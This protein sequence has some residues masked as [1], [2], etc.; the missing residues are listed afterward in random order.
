MKIVHVFI[1]YSIKYAGGTSD[2][3]YKI[4]K[5]QVDSGKNVE[6]WTGNYNL[7]DEL[8]DLSPFK[9]KIFKSFFDKQGLSIMPSLFFYAIFNLKKDDIIHFHVIRT[10]QNLILYIVARLKGINY[11]IDAHGAVP[12]HKKKKIL[13]NIYD[14][15]IGNNFIKNANSI[16]AES[17]IGAEEYNASY[18]FLDYKNIDILSPPFDVSDYKDIQKKYDFD[19]R[20]KNQ[21]SR[22][23]FVI[24]FLG[25]IH[26]IKGVDILIKFFNEILVSNSNFRLCIVGSDDGHL[27]YCKKLIKNYNIEK[28]TYFLGFM[29][30]DEKNQCLT[31]S[32]VVVQLSRFE[33]GAW[34]PIEAVLCGTPIIVSSHTGAGEDVKRLKAG[35]TVSIDTPNEFIR[36]INE[37]KNN[38]LEAK[39]ITLNARDFIIKYMSF[40]ARVGEY[41]KL[42][43]KNSN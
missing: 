28:Y 17:K 2:L 26:E 31:D 33:Q 41:Y 23:E 29:S 24:T 39:N 43:N 3:M 15:F 1:F 10:F 27:N 5:A 37:I 13:K 32:N 25:R 18:K 30:G 22:K 38:E 21:I 7:D 34:A 19:F 36:A 11:V 14:F 9:V 16:I 35:Y 20:K 42:Y 12:I 8:V 6:I 4:A 40:D